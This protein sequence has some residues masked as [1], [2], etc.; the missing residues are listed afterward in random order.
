MTDGNAQKA[1]AQLRAGVNPGE[2]QSEPE[3]KAEFPEL[4]V[5]TSQAIDPVPPVERRG[6]RRA[7]PVQQTGR[8]PTGVSASRP[9]RL[10][11]SACHAVGVVL[12]AV[13]ATSAL[14]STALL[15]TRGPDHMGETPTS[16]LAAMGAVQ[17]GEPQQKGNSGDAE[18]SSPAQ[19][20]TEFEPPAAAIGP[21]LAGSE[22]DHNKNRPDDRPGGARDGAGNGAVAVGEQGWEQ[23]RRADEAA[24]AEPWPE[25]AEAA[26]QAIKQRF[27]EVRGQAEQARQALKTLGSEMDQLHRQQHEEMQARH[28]HERAEAATEGADAVRQTERRHHQEQAALLRDQKIQRDRLAEAHGQL[29]R[30]LQDARRDIAQLREEAVGGE[31]AGGRDPISRLHVHEQPEVDGQP[32]RAASEQR[33]TAGPKEPVAAEPVTAESGPEPVVVAD[34]HRDAGEAGQHGGQ[35]QPPSSPRAEADQDTPAAENGAAGTV[36]ATHARPPRATK[37]AAAADEPVTEPHR[38]AAPVSQDVA[39]LIER[40]NR[41]LELGDLASARLYYRLAAGRGSA[42]GAMLM[43]M[44]FDPLY[45]ARTG[46]HGTQPQIQDALEWYGKAIAMGNQPAATR[47]ESLRSWLEQAAATGDAQAEAALQQLR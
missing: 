40:G 4:N 35:P 33:A 2:G 3:V 27:R 12:V 36:N 26:E 38:E 11:R 24:L 19:P 47:M 46:V 43:G 30:H 13:G 6:R 10:A 20:T 7:D 15:D 37:T 32:G 25:L 28:V 8:A 9:L 29:N 17:T 45:F 31:D 14:A 39:D 34:P 18:A 41:L 42:E 16:T 44:T 21:D 1:M 22:N 5:F 23:D